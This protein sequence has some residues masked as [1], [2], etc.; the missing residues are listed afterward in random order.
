LYK[1]AASGITKTFSFFS[2]SIVISAVIGYFINREQSKPVEGTHTFGYDMD[3]DAAM[4]TKIVHDNVMHD[5]S[6]RARVRRSG[7]R[8]RVKCDYHKE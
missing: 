8:Y 2:V 5:G 1:I 3:E 7:R 6:D 4:I